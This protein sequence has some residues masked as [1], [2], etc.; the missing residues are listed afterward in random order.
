MCERRTLC[1]LCFMTMLLPLFGCIDDRA[2]GPVED[3]HPNVFLINSGP[4]GD[5]AS[6]FF[7][8]RDSFGIALKAKVQVAPSGT[9]EGTATHMGR[10]VA[11]H[12]HVVNLD[13]MEL[14]GGTFSYA[15][16]TGGAIEGRYEGNITPTGEIDTYA[17][18][19]TL[20][21]DDGVI[22]G[23]NR[24][25]EGRGQIRGVLYP[26]GSLTYAF[27]GWLLHHVRPG[28]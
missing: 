13:A 9:G 11:E 22:P 8:G 26:D 4:G 5:A 1:F 6:K 15:G 23:L 7:T 21:V 25:A 3:E 27:D 10:L 12:D 2:L 17:L 14:R 19:G 18:Q 24:P 20:W 16:T 28:D